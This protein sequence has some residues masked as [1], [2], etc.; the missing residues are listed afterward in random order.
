MPDT[1]VSADAPPRLE[2]L[3]DIAARLFNE[4]GFRATSLAEIGDALGMNKASLY[5]YV[6][7]KDDLLTRVIYR[8]SQKLRDLAKTV[9]RDADDPAVALKQLIENHC[10][11]ILD[12]PDEFGT[13][14]FQRRYISPA[15]SSEIAGRER[16]YADTV[17]SLIEKGI[18][19]GA[20]RPMD[21]GVATQ[22]ILD[23]VNGILR[24]YRPNGRLSRD[25][26]IA[27]V[28]AFVDAAVT[29]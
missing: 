19:T 22:S 1:G 14:I 25:D 29:K 27:E 2:E 9:S 7:S 18:D 15:I 20:F 13:V 6:K 17:K 11:T 3:L 24:W 10:R 4:K 12:H 5:Y 26:A 28:V 21:A 16:T 8:A 23:A